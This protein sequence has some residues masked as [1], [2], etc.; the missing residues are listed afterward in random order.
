MDKMSSLLKKNLVLF[1]FLFLPLLKVFAAEQIII[2]YADRLSVENTTDVNTR[3][4]FGNVQITQG[5]VLLT[6]EKAIQYMLANKI[7]LEQKVVITQNNLTLKAPYVIYNGNTYIAE[8]SKGVEISDKDAKLIADRGNYSTQTHI[9]DFY[10]NVKFTDDSV[11]IYCEYINHNRNTEDSKAEGNVLIKGNQTNVFLIADKVINIANENYS[12]VTG[13]P[14][15][16]QIDTIVVSSHD[17]TESQLSEVIEFD[18]L[19]VKADTI[20]AFRGKENEHYHFYGNVEIIKKNISAIAQDA[21]FY[22]NREEIILRNKPI[23]W[24]D[25]S[26][27]YADSINILLSNNEVKKIHSINNAIA[28]TLN[29]TNNLNRKDQLAGNEIEIIFSSDSTRN[30]KSFG[31]AKSVYFMLT[32]GVADGVVKNSAEKILIDIAKDGIENIVL[33]NQVP[34]EYTPEPMVFGKEKEF[35]L[36]DFKFNDE[37]KPVKPDVLLEK[38]F[39]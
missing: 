16:Y 9:A 11:T 26:Q 20:E 32:E 14:V 3:A 17:T 18:T 1:I 12:I 6:C 25:S 24:Y 30:I 28:I 21:Y 4:L 13:N 34:G 22:K 7:E 5:N 36:P 8:A 23:I 37:N 39:R 38:Y 2:N 19:I 35:F 27:L 15:L 33:I 10:D 31:N 29:D